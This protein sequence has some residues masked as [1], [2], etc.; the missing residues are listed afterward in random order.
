MHNIRLI[1][2]SEAQ[3]GLPYPDLTRLL[4]RA[5]AH[6]TSE[7][8]TGILCYGSGLFLQAIEGRRT[9]VNTLYHSIAR[10]ERHGA[11][12]LMSVEEIDTRVFGEWSMKLVGWDDVATE[13]RR[14][15]LHRHSGSTI[16][17]PREMTGPQALEFLR[18]LAESERLSAA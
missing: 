4:V 11:C 14:R 15:I 6:N 3:P 5:R 7:A 2:A 13:N 12:Q 16:F 1:Y 10:D 18:E 9:A 8:I 17:D